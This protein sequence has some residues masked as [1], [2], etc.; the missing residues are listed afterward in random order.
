M[1][2]RFANFLEGSAATLMRSAPSDMSASDIQL[3]TRM[4]NLFARGVRAKYATDG[5]PD[6]AALVIDRNLGAGNSSEYCDPDKGC[7]SP[8]SLDGIWGYG[9][10][11]NFGEHLLTGGATPVNEFDEICKN[12]QLCLRCKDGRR[13]RRLRL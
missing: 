1:G 10:W 4:S 8:I 7:N 5:L 11:C 13:K 2:D 6:Q 9:C 12:L 3:K